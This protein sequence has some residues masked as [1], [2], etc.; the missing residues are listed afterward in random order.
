[1]KQARHK[2]PSDYE[3]ATPTA[4]KTIE[5]KHID[6]SCSYFVLAYLWITHQVANP[7]KAPAGSRDIPG[8]NSNPGILE[9]E[10]PG[11]FGIYHIKQNNDFKYFY[12]FLDNKYQKKSWDEIFG[13]IPS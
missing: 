5:L 10:F 4:K 2:Q 13:L 8:L 1:M 6:D 3:V 7:E 12:C 11:I 9:N